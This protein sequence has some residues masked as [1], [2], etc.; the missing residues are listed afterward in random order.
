MGNYIFKKLGDGHVVWFEKSNQWVRL[1]EPQGFLFQSWEKGV[2]AKEAALQ[3]QTVYQV[4]RNVAKQVVN[5]IFDSV[6]K[7]LEPDFPLPDLQLH[8]PEIAGYHIPQSK[9]HHYRCGEISFSI[10][11][12][13]AALEHYIHLPFSHLKVNAGS[14]ESVLFEVFPFGDGFALRIPSVPEKCFFTGESPQ[15]KYQL[16]VELASLLYGKPRQSWLS[17]I[18]ASAVK[19]G[20]EVLLLSSASGSGK[21]TMAALL[22]QKGFEFFSDDFVPLDMDQEKLWPFPAALSLKND[23]IPL[24]EKEGLP[25]SLKSSSG[26]LAYIDPDVTNFASVPLPARKLIFIRYRK[27]APLQFNEIAPEDALPLF[28]QEALVGDTLQK[29]SQFIDWFSRLKFYT[30]QYSNNEAAIKILTDLI[31]TNEPG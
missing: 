16:F 13:S 22:L 24:L 18:H 12:G 23:S 20:E 8:A 31:T 30:L 14:H 25:M 15:I 26:K 1:D 27:D 10:R 28:H 29:A 4:S 3:Y 11:Y 9:I 6:Q 7:L 17:Y 19:K 21:S 2:P 5:N